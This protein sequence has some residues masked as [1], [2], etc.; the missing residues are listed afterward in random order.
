MKHYDVGIFGLW[1]GH[2]YG[3]IITYFALSKVIESLNLSYAMIRNPLETEINIDELHRSHPLVF[4]KDRYNIT[5]LLSISEM[6]QLNDFFD[7]FLIGSD[8]MWNYY[9]SN[10]YR[11]SYFLDFAFDDK[12][13]I[14]YATSFGLSEYV[15]P[16][17]EKEITEKNLH[18]FNKISVRDDFSQRICK[19][20]FNISA[21]LLLDPVFLCPVEKY[22]ELIAEVDFK[23]DEGYIFAYVLNPNEIIGHEL[24]IIAETVNCRLIVVFDFAGDKEL[25]KKSL[26][27]SSKLVEYIILPDV[28]EWLYLLKNSKFVLTDSFHGTCFSIIFNKN[29]VVLKN[30]AR[31]GSRFPFILNEFGLL[32]HMIE[33]GDEF[34]DK[35]FELEGSF[36]DY[37]VV[38]KNIE[39]LKSYAYNWLDTAFTEMKQR[40]IS[41]IC[42]AGLA[43]EF[44][45]QIWEKHFILEN[46]VLIT[47]H[48]KNEGGNYA[49]LPLKYNIEKDKSYNFS[50]RFKIKTSSPI[51]NFHVMKKNTSKIQIIHTH[52]IT[53]KN[54]GTLIDLNI[55]FISEGNYDSFMVGAMQ[56]CGDE[57][58]LLIEDF[59]IKIK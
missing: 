27:I 31:G 51:F 53:T 16:P 38:W 37:S 30:D 20:E 9:L 34:S 55:D 4:A 22:E 36:I 54:E 44:N 1:Y 52:R 48:S 28:R 59:D 47:K 43:F 14:A 7:S 15:G 5:P 17:D 12:L 10:P 29:F 41:S 3:S 56:L 26:N 19:E 58:Y 25:Q 50:I 6:Y 33:N 2:N 40:N 8:Q 39:E 21:D 45:P 13:K 23:V 18:R 42:S 46:T 24:E 57:R 11:Q 35:Y 49:V 32:S